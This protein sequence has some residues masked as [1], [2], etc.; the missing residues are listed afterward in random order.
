VGGGEAVRAV[1]LSSPDGRHWVTRDFPTAGL[2]PQAG[3]TANEIVV[4]PDGLI[5]TGSD[6]LTPGAELWWSSVS[7]STWSRVSGYPPLGVWI[8][9]GEGSGLMPNGTLLGDGERMLAYRG[10]DKPVA[11]TSSDGRSWRTI[12]T[13]GSRP[14]AM[15][16]GTLVLM[17]IGVLWIG[18]DGSTWFGQPAP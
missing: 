14:T 18:N 13:G 15:G 10:G 5:V 8:G 4:G 7:G 2:D 1:T 12:V 3:S 6:G 16:S 17:P 11:W 9:Q